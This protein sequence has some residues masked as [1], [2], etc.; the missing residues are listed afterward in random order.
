MTWQSVWPDSPFR[1]RRLLSGLY[2]SASYF[3]LAFSLHLGHH[4]PHLAPT[5]IAQP[6]LVVCD[7]LATK[8]YHEAQPLS[9]AERNPEGPSKAEQ[10]YR[11]EG[12]EIF[13]GRAWHHPFCSAFFS[14]TL[15]L[16]SSRFV[17]APLQGY[18]GTV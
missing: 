14:Q 3:E 9:E 16:G 8:R 7:T 11:Q 5:T 13:A 18:S 6:N 12:A 2:Y 15:A 1:C 10:S 17:L 4:R